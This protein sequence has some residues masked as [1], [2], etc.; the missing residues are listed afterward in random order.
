MRIHI[1]TP[2]FVPGDAVS[3]D[4]LGM[5]RW[6]RRQGLETHIYAGRCPRGLRQKFR[7]LDSYRSYSHDAEDIALYHQSVGWPEGIELFKASQNRKVVKYHNVTPAEFFRP[8]NPLYVHACQK[9]MRDTRRLIQTAPELWLADSDF[10]AG[11]LVKLGVEAAI[12]RTV[13]PFHALRRLDTIAADDEL[14]VNLSRQTNL[15]FIGRVAPN[16]G[17]FHLLRAFAYYRKFLNGRSHLHIVGGHDFGLTNY[18][19][20]LFYEVRRLGLEG[21]VHFAGRV[22]SRRLKTYF[23][24]A[25]VFVCASEHEGFCVPLVEAMYYGIPIV[26]YGSS[27]VAHTLGESSLSWEIPSPSL[28]AESIVEI[29]TRPDVRAVL[30]QS[31]RQHY[32]ANFTDEAIETRFAD[33]IAPLLNGV[34]SHA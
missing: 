19:D 30:I 27:A 31:Q 7:R 23:A 2:C 28:L 32:Q 6:L 14:A 17:H 12:C 34:L 11:E 22:P 9:G 21:A 18:R 4:V 8:Y 29:E 1:L 25:S 20:E 24:N 15:L 26:A 10:N 13:P 16:K 5:C 33:A 3:H